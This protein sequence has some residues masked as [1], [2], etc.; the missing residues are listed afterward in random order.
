[1]IKSIEACRKIMKSP[2]SSGYP[3]L[4]EINLHTIFETVYEMKYS[5]PVINS[6]VSFVIY[7]FDP[8]SHWLDFKKDRIENKIR[9]IEG[10]GQSKDKEPFNKILNGTDDK[11]NEVILS[12]LINLTDWRWQTIFTLLDYHAKMIRF[13][14]D[15][16]D[17]EKSYDAFDKDGQKHTLTEEIDL[18]KITKVNK[19]KGELL[20][21]A[22]SARKKADDLFSEIRKDF[23]AVDIATQ[24]DLNFTFTETAKEKI[25][26]LSWRE[27]IKD[28]NRKK[29]S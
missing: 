7:A 28:R 24:S 22:I 20:D 9:I 11:I 1:M 13:V 14:Q 17:S 25:D 29:I 18:D 15:K 10:L 26:I 16:V 5:L 4:N 3:I 6:I 19:Q 2:D 8:D 27:F 12:Y 23:V 21:Q